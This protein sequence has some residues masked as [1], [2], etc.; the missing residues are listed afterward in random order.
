MNRDKELVSGITLVNIQHSCFV[1]LLVVLKIML[2]Q[3]RFLR[4]RF[5]LLMNSDV[6]MLDIK[7]RNK[8]APPRFWVRPHRNWKWWN[9]FPDG[10]IIPEEWKENFR[11]P[12]RLFY[13]L[14]EESR[15]YIEKQAK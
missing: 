14:C 13:I 5:L 1:K 12:E 10:N 2:A 9:D 15:P 11:M 4:K 7:K 8:R 3:K 6:K